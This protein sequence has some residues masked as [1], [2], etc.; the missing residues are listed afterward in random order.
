MAT[1]SIDMNYFVIPINLFEINQ[2]Q[3]KGYHSLTEKTF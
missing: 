3:Q 2:M 1:E